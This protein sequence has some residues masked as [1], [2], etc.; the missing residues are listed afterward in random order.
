IDC[1]RQPAVA[2]AFP[3]VS[4]ATVIPGNR[5]LDEAG[6]QARR[7]AIFDPY[8][9]EIDA[10]LKTRVGRTVY[11]IAMHSFTPVYLG[12]ERAMH[13]AVLYNRRPALSLALGAALRAEPGL[14][15][16]ENDPYRV[17]DATD[18]GVPVHAEA[19]GLDYIEIEIRQDLIASVSGQ[20]AWAELLARLL[21]QAAERMLR[22]G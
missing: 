18:Y 15:V 12:Q 3:E 17:S 6:K 16:A 8:H 13:V 4:E 20:M 11:Y 1:N 10:R 22:T 2:S 5:N 21:P 14:V 19:G 9:R 7:E